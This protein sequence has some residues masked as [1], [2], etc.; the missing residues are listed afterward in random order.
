MLP[1]QFGTV[2]L[3]GELT[4]PLFRHHPAPAIP[5]ATTTRVHRT[6]IIE[7]FKSAVA[8]K[9]GM[10]IRSLPAEPDAVRRYVEEL[11]LPYH[12][13]LESVVDRH[14]LA[15]GDEVDVVAE[16][17]E[18]RLDLLDTDTHQIWVAVDRQD[19]A[20]GDTETDF[21]EL[22]ATLAGYV[23]TDID[24]S[25]TVFDNPARLV[26]GDIYVKEPYRGTGL[27]RNLMAVAAERAR[28]E[29]IS[30]LRLDVDVDNERARAFY[31]KLGFETYRHKMCIDAEEL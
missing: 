30:E 24:A 2:S 8:R 10:E 26:V 9:P 3:W 19:D 16:E 14:A 28:T 11:W 15:S 31:E 7:R 1:P 20:D 13:D 4:V 18:Y 25:P 12:R 5:N 21:A 23:T 27:A 6:T 22:D 29:D 17:T